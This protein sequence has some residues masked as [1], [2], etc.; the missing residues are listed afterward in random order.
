MQSL[1]N[2][3]S[4]KITVGCWVYDCDL[5]IPRTDLK[6]EK[7]FISKVVL[8]LGVNLKYNFQIFLFRNQ[9]II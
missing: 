9:K 8:Q 1:K 4:N 7:I 3:N 6:K 2:Q 5:L